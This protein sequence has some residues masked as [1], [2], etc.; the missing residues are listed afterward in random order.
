MKPKNTNIGNQSNK[1]LLPKTHIMVTLPPSTRRQIEALA[2]T[3]ERSLSYICRRFVEQGLNV[4][5]KKTKQ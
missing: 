4:Q 1:S 5:Q 2:K 3:E